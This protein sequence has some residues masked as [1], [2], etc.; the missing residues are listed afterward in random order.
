MRNDISLLKLISE[1]ETD[2]RRGRIKSQEDVF[3]EIE[4]ALKIN[5]K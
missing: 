5:P 3:D 1:G 2:I 4:N